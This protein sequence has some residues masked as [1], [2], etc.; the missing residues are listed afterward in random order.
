MEVSHLNTL[1]MLSKAVNGKGW[2]LTG[3]RQ[4]NRGIDTPGARTFGARQQYPCIIFHPINCI[5]MYWN[6]SS[7]KKKKKKKTKPRNEGKVTI[8]LLLV[9]LCKS[10]CFVLLQLLLPALK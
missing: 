10:R 8:R 5:E 4:T 7:P 6:V 9:R 2:S 3:A 1:E